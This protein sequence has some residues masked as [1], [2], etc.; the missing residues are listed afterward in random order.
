MDAGTCEKGNRGRWKFRMG[1]A[2]EKAHGEEAVS[3]R[4]P[5]QVFQL[6]I[7]SGEGREGTRSQWD[8]GLC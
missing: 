3:I 6:Q 7:P 2:L 5:C 8:T 1:A 4:R